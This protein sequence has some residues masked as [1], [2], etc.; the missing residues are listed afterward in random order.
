MAI[1]K[2]S[3]GR[4]VLHCHVGPNAD[5]CLE[6][7]WT[8][9]EK[10]VKR[11]EMAADHPK[12]VEVRVPSARYNCFG[13]AYTASH[14]W[15]NKPDF[16]IA[17]DFL[18]VSMA[19]AKPGDVLVYEDD[20]EITHSAFVNQVTNGTIIKVRS[21]WGR[22]AAFIHDPKDVP[23]EYGQAVRLIRRKPLS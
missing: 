20:V 21:K 10:A 16:F 22:V 14:G 19:N 7:E 23:E 3:A 5:P 4:S 1:F 13:Y 12:A 15:F 9:A 18:P 17:D 11:A 2:T 8:L 6:R